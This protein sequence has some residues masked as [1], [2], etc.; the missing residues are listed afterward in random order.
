M[1]AD[2]RTEAEVMSVLDKMREGYAKRDLSGLLALFAT[3][4]DLVAIGSGA[5]EKRVGPDQLKV[6]LER[7]FAQSES[8]SMDFDRVSISA[9]GS[10]AWLAADCV[11]NAKVS[12]QEMRLDGR[13]TAV[14]EKRGDRWLIMQEH[15][16][17]PSGEQVEGQS[18]P[19]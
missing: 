13:L 14:L 12:G 1:K 10:V 18:F 9:A 5:D 16:S 3:D 2:A 8:F 4:A 17:M 19:T 6:Q 15:L 7:D 11:L